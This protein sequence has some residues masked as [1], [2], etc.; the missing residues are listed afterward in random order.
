[1]Y[2]SHYG[3][4]NSSNGIAIII[5]TKY[6]RNNEN[7][8]L[9][10]LKNTIKDNKAFNIITL[11]F[12]EEKFSK[13]QLAKD[14]SAFI[15]S[16][17]KTSII[18]AIHGA[19]IFK[20][21]EHYSIVG[22][23]IKESFFNFLGESI[24]YFLHGSFIRSADVL[25]AIGASTKSPLDVWQFSCQGAKL[26]K[27]AQNNLPKGSIYIAESEGFTNSDFFFNTFIQAM[28]S[29]LQFTFDELYQNYLTMS[30]KLSP[31]YWTGKI[32]PVKAIIGEQP[33]K[34]IE[35]AESLLLEI[36]NND[37]DI[38]LLNKAINIFCQNLEDA[39]PEVIWD[40]SWLKYIAVDKEI[41]VNET[42]QQIEK[43]KNIE[44][45]NLSECISK[46]NKLDYITYTIKDFFD[47]IDYRLSDCFLHDIGSRVE[48]LTALAEFYYY[49][50][51]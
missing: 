7:Y 51:S 47:L 44:A 1:M 41:C 34:A 12:S 9:E 23:E 6:I 31:A 4:P 5:G 22:P 2:L 35:K 39:K 17:S 50:T 3:N 16:N 43:I 21:T 37:I 28:R 8:K 33:I 20:G 45:A 13:E 40:E 19:E 36:K 25:E 29:N 14:L 49:H 10:L 11:D 15:S 46:D 24:N 18:I 42:M 32:D 26:L 38:S 27:H 48:K 30:A